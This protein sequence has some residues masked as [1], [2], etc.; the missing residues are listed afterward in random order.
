MTRWEFHPARAAFPRFALDWDKL[1]MQLYDGH[2][3]YDSRFVGPMLEYF[4]SGKEQLCILRTN[5][6]VAGALILQ[7]DGMGRW[8]TFKPSQSQATALL[9]DD[10]RALETL[11]KALPGYAWSLE[12]YAVD[13]RYSPDLSRIEVASLASAQALTIGVDANIEFSA[14]WNERSKNLR[15]NI[16]RYLNRAVNG[17][18]MPV[19][20]KMVSPVEMSLAVSRFGELETA[21]W[22]GQAGTAIS[23]DNAQGA[24]YSEVLGRFALS[25]QA[26]VYELRVGDQLAASRLVIANDRMTVILKTTYDEALALIAPGRLLLHRVIQEQLDSQTGKTIEFYTNATRDQYEWSSFSCVIRNI[27]LFRNDSFATAYSVLKGLQHRLRDPKSRSK[28]A[29]AMVD[30]PVE[31]TTCM[32]IEDLFSEQYD[33]GEFAAKDSIETSIDWFDLVQR[34]VYRDDPGVRCYLVASDKRPLVILPLR[35]STQGGI[36]TVESLGNYYTSLYAPLL[37]KDSDP[38]SIRHMLKKASR[39]HGGAHVM[40]FAPMDPK[41]QAYATLLSELRAIGFIPF[42]YFCFGNWFL[43]VESNWEGYLKKRSANL[44][45]SIRRRSKEFAASGGTLELVSSP[46]DI[47]RAI[48]EFQ[49]VYSASWKV[50]E[51]YPDFVPSLIRRLSAIGMLRLGI[52]HLDEKPIAAQL[53]IVGQ[54]KASI[55]K[56]AYHKAFSAYSPGTVLT[57]FL[58][59]HVIERDRVKEVDFLIGD[60][61]YKPFWMSHRRERWGIVAF[62][63]GTRRGL[64]L[65]ANEISWRAAKRLGRKLRQVFVRSKQ[66]GNSLANV[67]NDSYHRCFGS[68][69]AQRA[70]AMNWTLHPISQ[71]GKHAAQWDALVRSRPGTP[72]LESAFLQPSV[73]IFGTGNE[74]LCLLESKGRL[75]AAAIMQRDRKGTWQTFQPSQL[76][77]GAW[78]SDGN[79]DLVKACSELARQLP[80]WA[81]GIGVSQLDPRFQA[82]PEECSNIRTQDYIQTA[83]VN[84]EGGFETYWEARGKNLK[85]NMRKQRNKLQSESTNTRLECITAPEDVKQAIE[86]YGLLESRGWKAADGTAIRSDN[87]QGIFYRKMLEN[88]CQL[89]RGRI[90]R[91]WFG[92]KVVAMDLCIHDQSAIVILKTTYD[93]S[94]KTISPSTLMRQDQFQHIFDE[95]RFSRIEFY[96]KI[97]EWHTRWTTQSRTL[98]HV[99]YYRWEWLKKLHARISSAPGQEIP[100]NPVADQN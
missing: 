99:T 89:G 63:P 59:H 7:A 41:S 20:A 22:K 90:Y 15:A 65:L 58:L 82:R 62:N 18:G 29:E 77:L 53:W 97:M 40:R 38:L 72:F 52:A 64:A 83:W 21:G 66:I 24:F 61:E 2:P 68:L 55:Y 34:Q 76:P 51:P 5:G 19:L 17:F 73:D 11:L 26:A 80:G 92:E 12:L 84:I 46:D 98:F 1:N 43:T 48:A 96:G 4:G 81:L 87:A 28:S 25:N 9:V 75:R 8:S 54:D 100:E 16:R 95:R 37:S 3:L 31:V 74:M 79:I 33:L 67:W 86:D 47:E 50:A 14:Y 78:I 32:R 91:Y 23:I 57:S 13:P 93:E 45:S 70:H 44:R 49:A 42:R 36:R 71:L 56:V 94:Y 30:E 85:Q 88:Y 39:D 35:L 27:H 6:C 60:D 69:A 10:A